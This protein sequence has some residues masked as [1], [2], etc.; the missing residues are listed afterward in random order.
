MDFRELVKNR[1]FV[2]SIGQIVVETFCVLSEHIKQ[3]SLILLSKNIQ[4][5]PVL[6]GYIYIINLPNLVFLGLMDI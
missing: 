4:Y 3:K 1:Y 5:I 6:Y 2:F